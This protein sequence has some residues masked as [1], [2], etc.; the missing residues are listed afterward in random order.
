VAVDGKVV[1]EEST[2]LNEGSTTIKLST[3]SFANGIYFIQIK[4]VDT[5]LQSKVIVNH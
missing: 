1:M 5:T 3:A 4:T 2:Q